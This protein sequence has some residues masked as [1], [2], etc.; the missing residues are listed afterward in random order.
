M[1]GYPNAQQHAGDESG[2]GVWK[3]AGQTTGEHLRMARENGF[4][5]RLAKTDEGGSVQL[6]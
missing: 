5:R 3:P 2:E 1:P 6:G 4:K